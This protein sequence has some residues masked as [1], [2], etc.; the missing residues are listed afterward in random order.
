MLMICVCPRPWVWLRSRGCAQ[1]LRPR[2][3][4]Q[5]MSLLEV[6]VR[7]LPQLNGYGLRKHLHQVYVLAYFWVN[8]CAMG[9]HFD[10]LWLLL[11]PRLVWYS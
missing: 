7:A 11:M 4:S 3:E 1:L 5:K 9:L 2:L 6:D 10:E 8:A